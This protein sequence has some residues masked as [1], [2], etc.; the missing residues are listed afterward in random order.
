[1][2]Q[3]RLGV[4][5]RSISRWVTGKPIPICSSVSGVTETEA[6]A[7]ASR[8]SSRP[9]QALQWTCTWRSP[10]RPAACSSATSGRRRSDQ[11]VPMCAVTSASSSRASSTSATVVSQG[12]RPSSVS[13]TPI[14]SRSSAEEKWRTAH[15]AGV[16]RAVLDLGEGRRL[17]RHRVH[18]VGEGAP[19]PRLAQAADRLVGVIGGVEAVREVEHAGDARVERFERADVVAG[20]DVLGGVDAGRVDADAEEVVEQ[21]PVGADPAHRGLPDVA[22]GVDEARDRSAARRRRCARRRRPGRGRSRRSGR[23]RSAGRRSA[24]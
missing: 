21:R 8:S 1:M 12:T 16:R 13:A 2:S 10:S 22:V 19:D 11:T 3:P 15:P 18:A 7:S 4:I 14:R 9:L 17:E 23:P 5:P 24:T 20:V 6:P